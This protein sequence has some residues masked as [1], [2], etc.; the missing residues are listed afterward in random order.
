M[1]PL[2]SI[3]DYLPYKRAAR[4]RLV[5]QIR[6]GGTDPVGISARVTVA[7][8]T[9]V[10]R[11]V[12]RQHQVIS[13]SSPDY[14][15]YDLG[16]T[17]P[18]LQLGVLGSCIAHTVLIHA[19]ERGV[20]LDSVDVDVNA[21]LDPRGGVD[22][23]DDATKQPTNLRYVVHVESPAAAAEVQALIAHVDAVCPVLNL[24]RTPARVE[25]RLR[26][27]TSGASS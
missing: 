21:E 25:S 23:F 10:R 9:G 26:L 15:G 18:E 24:I 4:S 20:L 13:D 1:L 16:P 14:A 17:S 2:N 22:G 19:A 3:R 7:G 6:S 27:T 12:I 8:A 11:I 5:E